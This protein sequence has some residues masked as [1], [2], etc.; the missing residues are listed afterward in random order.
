VQ[1]AFFAIIGT[2]TVLTYFHAKRT[3]LQPLRTEV[4]K[5]QLKLMSDVLDFLTAEYD[6]AINTVFPLD[7]LVNINTLQMFDDYAELVFGLEID[8]DQRP[9]APQN[10]PHYLL[11]HHLVVKAGPYRQPDLGDRKP[12]PPPWSA[13]KYEAI[14]IPDNF[15]QAQERVRTFAR[16]PLA[17]SKLVELLQRLDEELHRRV[18]QVGEVLTDCARE[19]PAMYPTAEKLKESSFSWVKNRFNRKTERLEPAI[20]Q[21]TD[22]ARAYFGP[23]RLLT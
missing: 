22:Y 15:A 21:I 3:I 13:Y 23:E 20:D 9:Y 6:G 1:I 5:Q 11:P 2:V 18:V 12:T 17:P 4:F 19:M 7:D 8:R 14:A 10:C 16:S